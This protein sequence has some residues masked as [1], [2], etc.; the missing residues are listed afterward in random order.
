M[1]KYRPQNP[2]YHIC[3]LFVPWR[4]FNTYYIRENTNFFISGYYANEQS[5]VFVRKIDCI[6]LQNVIKIGFPKEFKLD[7]QEPVKNG[8]YGKYVSQ[9]IVFVFKD[10]SIIAWNVRP[11]TKK[12]VK[13]LLESIIEEYP[14]QIGNKLRRTLG[15]E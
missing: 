4:F 10:S 2:I 8:K 1:K 15:I 12:Q 6:G 7:L 3:C 14:I 13:E 5:D 11:Y 9:E